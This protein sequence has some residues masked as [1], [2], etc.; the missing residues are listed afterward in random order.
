MAFKHHST[1][2]GFSES[3]SMNTAIESD[4]LKV[5]LKTADNRSYEGEILEVK[6]TGAE[7]RFPLGDAPTLAL[8]ETVTMT[9]A[10]PSQGE[11]IQAPA[12]VHFR[13]D[14]REHRRFGLEFEGSEEL[15]EKLSGEFFQLLFSRRSL[16]RVKPDSAQ[17]VNVHVR[18]LA[19][20]QPPFSYPLFQQ[21]RDA[22]MTGELSDISA[23][24]LAFKIDAHLDEVLALTDLI[25]VSPILP[26]RSQ[27]LY[28]TSWIRTRRLEGAFAQYG[29]EFVANLSTYFECK[30]DTIAEYIFQRQQE[31]S[32]AGTADDGNDT[33]RVAV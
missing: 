21:V 23:T 16:Y 32:T 11:F 4:G 13:A 1:W 7:T 29:V 31:E 30:Q 20:A 5:G 33:E 10:S 22:G 14:T 2:N 28:L 6:I 9:F 8:G 12:R 26:G 27:D 15:Q 17:P 25:E 18:L 19:G 3:R 24:G